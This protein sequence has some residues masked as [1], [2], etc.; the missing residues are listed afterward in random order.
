MYQEIIHS[1]KCPHCQKGLSLT[2]PTFEN[3][4]V[5]TGYL[6]CD[7]NQVWEIKEG[8]LDFRV[9]EQANV[10]RWSEIT[11]NMSFEELDEM[12]LKETPKNQ[13]ELL[14]KAINDIIRFINESKPMVILDI[15][16]GRGMLL[17]E[18]AKRINI[19]LNLICTDLSYVVLNADRLK[20]QKCN[21]KI[22]ISYISC[23]ATRLPIVDNSIGLVLSFFGI[24]NMA[25]L[26]KKGLLEAKRVLK[27]D[28]YF[29]NSSVVIKEESKGYSILKDYYLNNKSEG[30]EIFTL[31]EK[32]MKE[33]QDIGFK[34]L[35][36]KLLGESIGQKNELDLI[37][38]EGE[39][40]G[41]GNIYA[42]K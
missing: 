16:T 3:K 4:E 2:Q 6:H 21:P 24:A 8:I 31:H 33:Y 23:D 15:A 26:I 29:L 14:D 37:P 7:C 11:K 32:I 39:W 34:D 40:F 12:I 22:K 1:L 18:L 30:A 36:F 19:E 42:K 20:I 13:R 28:H 38:F 35:K 9:E 10:N 5:Y 25:S 41:I 27:N 17:N